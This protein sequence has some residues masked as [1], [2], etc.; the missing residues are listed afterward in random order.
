[1]LYDNVVE[2]VAEKKLHQSNDTRL[3]SAKR[4]SV[5]MV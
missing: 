1:M 3:L 2:K 4:E 5:D